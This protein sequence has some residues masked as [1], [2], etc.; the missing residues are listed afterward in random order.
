MLKI[1][2]KRLK[3]FKQTGCMASFVYSYNHAAA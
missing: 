2:I 3:P 1:G